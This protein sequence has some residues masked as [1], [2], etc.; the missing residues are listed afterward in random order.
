MEDKKKELEIAQ[1]Q[2]RLNDLTKTVLDKCH[3]VES[4]FDSVL[5]T[6]KLLGD[7]SKRET[8]ATQMGEFLASRNDEL[9]SAVRLLENILD[10]CELR[11]DD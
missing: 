2:N 8:L 7:D 3:R 4:R 11:M 10:R 5:N 1:E 6:E 9:A